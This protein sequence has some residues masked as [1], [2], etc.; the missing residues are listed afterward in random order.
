[1]TASEIAALVREQKCIDIN[2]KNKE[3]AKKK[4]RRRE[5]ASEV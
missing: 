5:R 1:M 3:K 4:K 2:Y